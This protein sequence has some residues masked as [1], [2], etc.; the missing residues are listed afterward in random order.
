G[1]LQQA[2]FPQTSGHYLAGNGLYLVIDSCIL[3]AISF[4][5]SFLEM[6]TRL[7]RL[8]RFLIGWQILTVLNT[9]N[10]FTFNFYSHPFTLFNNIIASSFL[11]SGGL[12][13]WRTFNPAKVYVAAW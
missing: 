4:A 12:Y 13:L 2:F 9:L 7:P 6:K 1:F 11:L 3:A 10:G 8:N 5:R